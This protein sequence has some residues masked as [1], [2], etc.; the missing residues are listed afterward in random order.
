MSLLSQGLATGFFFW[1]YEA[2][3]AAYEREGLEVMDAVTM[4]SV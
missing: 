3:K 4:A 1:I 2:R